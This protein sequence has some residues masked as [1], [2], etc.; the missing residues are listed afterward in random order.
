MTAKP[1]TAVSLRGARKTVQA[2]I[3]MAM[4]PPAAAASCWTKETARA[5]TAMASA[6]QPESAVASCWTMEVTAAA[7]M[8]S[9][10]VT[11]KSAVVLYWTRGAVAT[12]MAMAVQPTIAPCC[13]RGAT[14]LSA[15]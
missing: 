8:P 13:M 14:S 3:V 10:I 12:A 5:I 2:A 6:T 15:L 7:S 4:R 1:L 11:Q 9:V